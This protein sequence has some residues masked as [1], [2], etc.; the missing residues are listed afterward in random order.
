[1]TIQPTE[2]QAAAPEE[3]TTAPEEQAAA[4]IEKA[5][6]SIGPLPYLLF[7]GALVVIGIILFVFL[8]YRQ[9]KK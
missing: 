8:R 6:D 9:E 3:Q 1:V 7:F 2:E 4:P 5:E